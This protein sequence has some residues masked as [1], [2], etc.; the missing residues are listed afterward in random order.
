MVGTERLGRQEHYWRVT[1]DDF[2][3]VEAGVTLNQAQQP[4]EVP[5]N[6]VNRKRLNE[7]NPG[8]NVFFEVPKSILYARRDSNPQPSVPK[9]DALSNCATGACL[10]RIAEFSFVQVC[11]C[12]ISRLSTIAQGRSPSPREVEK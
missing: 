8:E 6:R 11:P 12:R 1:E 4:G 10:A 3:K 9:T 5:R 7:E 2:N